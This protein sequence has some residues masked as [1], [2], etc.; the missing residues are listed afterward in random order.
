MLM[1]ASLPAAN[2]A[3]R[4]EAI[5]AKSIAGLVSDL[6]SNDR[7]AADLAKNEL[8]RRGK[9]AVPALA[10]VVKDM[11]SPSR[12]LAVI[13]LGIAKDPDTVPLLVQCLSDR[14]WHVRGRAAY[15]LSQIGGQDAKDA[16]VGFLKRCLENPADEVNITKATEAL[17]QLPDERALPLLLTVVNR[18][19]L[20]R[21][22]AGRYAVIALGRIGD[23]RASAP[24]A[25]LLNVSASYDISDDYIL[26]EAIKST[27]GKE[28]VS[29]LVP[30][31]AAVAKRIEQDPDPSENEKAL[32]VG[33]KGRQKAYDT[34]LFVRANECL[35]GIAQTKPEG[36]S[37]Q[38][39]VQFWKQ[40]LDSQKEAP[41]QK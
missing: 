13:S 14:D 20:K 4:E 15:S 38:E 33:A 7:E 3:M 27:R 8:G 28:A 36:R 24:I 17:S 25:R 10:A 30:Y 2:G 9:E 39:I 26:L 31:L 32:M 21:T 40:Y 35:V 6:K 12:N 29:Y 5:K 34:M 1:L 16:I 37:V 11:E 41:I 22:Y 19:D 23:P 18:D